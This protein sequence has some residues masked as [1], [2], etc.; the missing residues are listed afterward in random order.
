MRKYILIA[1]LLYFFVAFAWSIWLVN[2]PEDRVELILWCL[3][4]QNPVQKII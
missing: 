2:K 3:L 1:L 4:R